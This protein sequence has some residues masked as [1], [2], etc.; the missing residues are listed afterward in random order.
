MGAVGRLRKRPEYLRVA[1]AR[2]KWVTPGM[3][4]QACARSGA[5]GAAGEAEPVEAGAEDG[6]RVGIT[7]SRKVGN[8]VRRNRAR[9]RLRAAARE[10]LPEAGQPGTDYV[11]IGRAGTLT[12]RYA[13]LVTD[14]RQAVDKL[15]RGPRG[16]PSARGHGDG[17]RRRRGRR[18]GRRSAKD[19]GDG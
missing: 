2:R 6:P 17:G 5:V 18:G 19:G 11:L 10:V 9:R 13:D 16:G 1:A 8:A 14:L 15:N 4:V 7:V 3:V 12:R